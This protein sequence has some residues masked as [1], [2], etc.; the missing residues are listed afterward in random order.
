VFR[1]GCQVLSISVAEAREKSDEGALS[2]EERDQLEEDEG[3]LETL[4]NK[5]FVYQ[6][7]ILPYAKIQ[8]AEN[9]EGF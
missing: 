8:Y 2:V 3:E 4:Q 1:F 7:T 9:K 5:I 6:E